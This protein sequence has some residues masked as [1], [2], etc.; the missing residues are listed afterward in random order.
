MA[1][2]RRLKLALL[3]NILAPY[4]LPIY[5]ALDQQFDLRIWIS[6]QEDNRSWSRQASGN[7]LSVSRA[8]GFTLKWRVRAQ[9]GQPTQ[10]LKYFHVNPGYL[11]KLLAFRP[12]AVISTEMGFR[13]LVA[14][15][16]GWLF[17]KPVW[18]W[19]GGTLHTERNLSSLKRCVRALFARSAC[20]FISYG[21]TSTEYLD[22]L[23]IPEQRILQ[24]QNCVD[25][26]TFQPEGEI[27]ALDAPHPRVLFVGQLIGRKGTSQ[28]LEAAAQAW[29]SGHRFSL[30]VVGDGPEREDLIRQAEHLGLPGL[31]HIPSLPNDR[32]P[33]VYRSCDLMV[34]PT[35]EDVWGLVVN[36]ALLCGVPVISS[37]YA[38]CSRELLGDQ[39]VFDPNDVE[40]F[41]HALLRGLNAE[42]E[43]PRPERLQRCLDV[44][45]RIS[46]DVERVTVARRSGGQS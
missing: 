25:E 45:D 34:F 6:G 13:S 10:D 5:S 38:G 33:S 28:L 7:G 14:L 15:L 46:T 24:V 2:Q 27:Y 40:A 11:W 20:R 21:A 19:W 4:R 18:I 36:E 22:A 23:G 37:I 12:D 16:F 32:M 8:W 44:A 42:I 31:V 3:T 39:N 26:R 41:S 17:R 35:M 1:A 30:V 9:T 43:P 29:R